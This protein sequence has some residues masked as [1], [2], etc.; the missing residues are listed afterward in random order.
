M[1]EWFPSELGKFFHFAL[2]MIIIFLICIIILFLAIELLMAYIAA[3]FT[4]TAKSTAM[5]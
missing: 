1:F 3:C 2:Q 5:Q 4:F